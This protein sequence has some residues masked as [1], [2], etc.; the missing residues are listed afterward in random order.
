M[1]DLT[2]MTLFINYPLYVGFFSSSL[3]KATSCGDDN[4][5]W[6]YNMALIS[7]VMTQEKKR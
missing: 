1:W 2:L 3:D 4:T 6:N 5:T 7:F